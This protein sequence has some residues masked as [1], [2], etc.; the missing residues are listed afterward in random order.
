MFILCGKGECTWGQR[1]VQGVFAF[2][3]R[4]E[5]RETWKGLDTWELCREKKGCEKKK[6]NVRIRLGNE[7]ETDAEDTTHNSGTRTA[8]GHPE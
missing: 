2:I 4:E 6:K 8:E 7:K 5:T 3:L 1:S